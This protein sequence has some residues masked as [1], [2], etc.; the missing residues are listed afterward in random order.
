MPKNLRKVKYANEWQEAADHRKQM[1]NQMDYKKPKGERSFTHMKLLMK[2]AF[3][4]GK[5]LSGLRKDS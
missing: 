3:T 1:Q 4:V 2:I 5:L